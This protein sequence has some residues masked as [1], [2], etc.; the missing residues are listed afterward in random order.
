MTRIQ[1]QCADLLGYG[2]SKSETIAWLRNFLQ[3][4]QIETSSLEL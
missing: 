1:T 2:S 3:Q 4:K